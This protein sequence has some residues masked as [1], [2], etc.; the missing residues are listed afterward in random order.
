MSSAKGNLCLQVDL[1]QSASLRERLS[2][3]NTENNNKK[4]LL[5]TFLSQHKTKRSKNLFIQSHF[6]HYCTVT[7]D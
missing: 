7:C 3:E 2:A 4:S 5:F 1:M 6:N